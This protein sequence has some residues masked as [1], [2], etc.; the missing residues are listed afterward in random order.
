MAA[1]A[2]GRRAAVLA[3][4]SN[5]AGARGPDGTTNIAIGEGV[6]VA[7]EHRSA[8]KLSYLIVKIKFN[9]R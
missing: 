3:N 6:A 4:F 7:N 2:A 5:A 8:W 1:A 9:F